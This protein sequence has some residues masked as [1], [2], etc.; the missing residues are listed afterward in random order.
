MER[1]GIFHWRLIW[2]QTWELWRIWIKFFAY[3][4]LVVCNHQARLST[5]DLSMLQ[6]TYIT[7]GCKIYFQREPSRT[8]LNFCNWLFRWSAYWLYLVIYEVSD[9]GSSVRYFRGYQVRIFMVHLVNITGV[10]VKIYNGILKHN[11]QWILYYVTF[12]T[13]IS[14]SVGSTAGY[15][16]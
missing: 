4:T 16:W 13:D 9:L 10:R 1:S 6:E 3:I 2:N 5:Y 8:I 7:W 14:S 15:I 12:R 11:Y